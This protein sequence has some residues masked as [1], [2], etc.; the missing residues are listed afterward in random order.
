MQ[1]V[2]EKEPVAQA[3]QVLEEPDQG[4]L[5]RVEQPV[6]AAIPALQSLALRA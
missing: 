6:L 2:W 4:A 1:V 5:I 3:D